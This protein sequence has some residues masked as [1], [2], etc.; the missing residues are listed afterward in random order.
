MEDCL[1]LGQPGRLTPQ[2]RLHPATEV[3][4]VQ[5]VAEG[6]VGQV[7][8]L[9]AIQEVVDHHH[10]LPAALVQRLDQI[11]ADEAGSACHYDH[12]ENPLSRGVRL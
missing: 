6:A 1:D 11:R 10:I 2:F 5:V 7:D 4:L 3:V 12:G 8:E 9:G